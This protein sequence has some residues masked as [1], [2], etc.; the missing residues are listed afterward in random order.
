MYCQMVFIECY[1]CFELYGRQINSLA[2]VRLNFAKPSLKTQ[3][4]CFPDNFYCD[5]NVEKLVLLEY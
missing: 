1:L 2:N 5:D 3:N 4:W